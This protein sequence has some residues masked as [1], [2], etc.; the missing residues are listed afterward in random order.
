MNELEL[1]VI[2]LFENQRLNVKTRIERE[3]LRTDFANENFQTQ[4]YKIT[5]LKSFK[6]LLI[7][8]NPLIFEGIK[9]PLLEIEKILFSYISSK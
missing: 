6:K 2:S 8:I 1:S 9:D 4:K 3:F 7:E 5:K